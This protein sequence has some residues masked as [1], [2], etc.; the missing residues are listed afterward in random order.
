MLDRWI[1]WGFLA[2]VGMLTVSGCV[3]SV[4]EQPATTV[5]IEGNVIDR[6]TGRGVRGAG[7]HVTVHLGDTKLIGKA[8]TG[9]AGHFVVRATGPVAS[10]DD[11]KLMVVDLVV[12]GKG[13]MELQQA[14][15]AHLILKSGSVLVLPD[16]ML[17]RKAPW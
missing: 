17:N 7:V 16:V 4:V 15:P 6:V 1:V 14:I 12:S 13:Y 2:V 10:T 9:G 11:A 3:S 8:N 5:A